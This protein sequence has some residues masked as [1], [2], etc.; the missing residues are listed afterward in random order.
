MK[1]QDKK[2]KEACKTLGI[3]YED[4]QSISLDELE[5]ICKKAMKKAQNSNDFKKMRELADAYLTIKDKP[6]L[7]KNKKKRRKS[8]KALTLGIVAALGI[9]GYH[10]VHQQK[11]D[12]SD[13]YINLEEQAN[14]DYVYQPI[15][16][17]YEEEEAKDYTVYRQ[18]PFNA[19]EQNFENISLEYGVSTDD[20]EMSN[21][22]ENVENGILIIPY[23][24]NADEL[25]LVSV[26]FE[27]TESLDQFVTRTETSLSTLKELN[28]E[29]FLENG[30]CIS[31]SLYVP[32]YDAIQQEVTYVK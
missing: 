28:S 20:L 18:I 21:T 14:D 27:E 6:K 31:S 32:D 13:A 10:L 7:K 15:H 23:S 22:I 11:T 12:S 24:V 3:S 5:N 30:T 16:N 17:T 25:S 29:A 8:H 1:S 4:A 26:P 9:G 2:F 19:N